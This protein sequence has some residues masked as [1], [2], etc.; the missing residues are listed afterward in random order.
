MKIVGVCLEQKLP[1]TDDFVKLRLVAMEDGK[2]D[3]ALP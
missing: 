1:K 2:N 3:R